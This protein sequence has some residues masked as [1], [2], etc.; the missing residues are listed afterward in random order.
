MRDKYYL[1]NQPLLFT[2]FASSL[3][4][5]D[6]NVFGAALSF[7]FGFLCVSLSISSKGACRA[8]TV[9]SCHKGLY[10]LTKSRMIERYDR[11]NVDPI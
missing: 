4:P 8:A 5:S 3:W 11:V 7:A 10:Y 2:L 1:E 9:A 6:I